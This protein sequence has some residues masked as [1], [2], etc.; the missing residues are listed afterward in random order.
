[1]SLKDE[2]REELKSE[3]RKILSAVLFPSTSAYVS[4]TFSVS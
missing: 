2:E 1:M 3:D 4:F